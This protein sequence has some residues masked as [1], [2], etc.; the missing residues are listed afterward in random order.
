MTN[1]SPGIEVRW[2]RWEDAGEAMLELRRHVFVE[3]QGFAEDVVASPRDPTGVH[4]GALVD[5]ALVATIAAYLYE[6]GAPELAAL[7]L[8][9]IDGLTVQFSKRM[10]LAAHRGHGITEVIAAGLFRYV[11]ESLRPARIFITLKGVHRQ[12][13]GHYARLF[14][15]KRHADVGEGADATIV[16]KVEGEAGLRALYLKTRAA[17]E[18][19]LRRCPV[20]VPSLVRFLADEGRD[21]LFPRAQLAAENL[22]VA[23]LSVADELPRLA[24]Q[25]RLLLAEQRPRLAA[26]EFPPTPSS[27]LDVGTGT[28]VYL[29]LIAGE[30]ALAGRSIKGLEPSP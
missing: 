16:M 5:G 7:G 23:P 4:L 25:N 27:L 22:Y 6:P 3:E 15:F 12:L 14:N 1:G 17:A 21:A 20:S 26:T 2:L 9:A 19:A 8:P 18:S 29:A 28:G 10:E 11:Y 30:P 13:E 24:A